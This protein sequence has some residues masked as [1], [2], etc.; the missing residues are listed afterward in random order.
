M[1]SIPEAVTCTFERTYSDTVRG[2][3]GGRNLECGSATGCTCPCGQMTVCADVLGGRGSTWVVVG[4]TAA[5]SRMGPVLGLMLVRVGPG[6][7]GLQ[8]TDD[9]AELA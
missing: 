9:G 8:V 6:E 2:R 5:A 7:T 1:S 3:R 4:R